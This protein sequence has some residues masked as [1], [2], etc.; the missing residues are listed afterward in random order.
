MDGTKNNMV[1]RQLLLLFIDDYEDDD[2][3]L[4]NL[5]TAAIGEE[6]PNRLLVVISQ[7]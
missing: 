6:L 3:S 1:K 7:G 4:M 5:C 2:G